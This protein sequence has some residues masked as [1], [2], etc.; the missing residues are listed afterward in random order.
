MLIIID[1][2]ILFLLVNLIDLV[3]TRNKDYFFIEVKCRS[4][5][6]IDY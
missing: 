1:A 4:I 5:Q 2:I 6:T 3:D